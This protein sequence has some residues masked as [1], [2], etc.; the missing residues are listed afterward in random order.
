MSAFNIES[1]FGADIY[2]GYFDIN[3]IL[4]I[5]EI[6]DKVMSSKRVKSLIAL[7]GRKERVVGIAMR[8]MAFD[9]LRSTLDSTFLPYDPYY[10]NDYKLLN[11]RRERLY[12]AQERFLI[13]CMSIATGRS[14]K[15]LKK[16]NPD[17]NTKELRIKHTKKLSLFRYF[18]Q[19]LNEH[20][21]EYILTY[22]SRMNKGSEGEVEEVVARTATSETDTEQSSPKTSI[23][24]KPHVE[25]KYIPTSFDDETAT[26]LKLFQDGHLLLSSQV[27][28]FKRGEQLEILDM[29]KFSRRL[30]ESHTRN[31]FSLM[32][33]RHI[34]DASSYLEQHAMGMAVL[35]IHFAKAM[36]LSNAYVEVIC[37]GALLFDLGR[38]RLPMT[39][40]AKSTKMTSSEFDLF[41]KHIQFGEQ[42]LQKCEGIPKAVYQMLYDH[43]EKMDGSGYPEGKQ[44]KEISVY[45]KIA[46]IIDAYDAIT[47]EQPHKPSIGPIKACQKLQ[48]E[49]GLAFD[50]ELLAVFLKHIGSVPVGSCVSLSNG[51]VGFVLTLNKSFQPSLVRQVYSMANKSFIESSDIELNK[52]ANL[53]TEVIIEE[54]IDPQS[55]KLQ[56][57]DHIS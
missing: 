56:F 1:C 21:R 43:H 16:L 39:M 27:E 35:G 10:V 55:L 49:S 11:S 12:D 41:R 32:A 19:E 50:K 24:K 6:K 45:G 51:R 47:S 52:S 14:V 25:S 8:Q 22:K 13:L 33:I 34:K 4:N 28:R 48:E 53:R 57:I 30:I 54:E 31:N 2:V 3:E 26:A 36:K 17:L 46:A 29:M 42:I 9:I 23:A 7:H 18:R 15:S 20:T 5:M 40:V 44:D 37:L 38:F